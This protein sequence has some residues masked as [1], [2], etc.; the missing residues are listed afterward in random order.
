[1]LPI[2]TSKVYNRLELTTYTRS[3]VSGLSVAVVGCGAL[4]SEVAR[5]LGLLGVGSVM[6]IDPDIV[7]PNNFTHSPYLRTPNSCGRFKAEVLAEN[8]ATHFPD[9]L[10]TALPCEIADAGFCRL[11]RCS[12]LF[13][14]TDNALARVET[15][16]SA[17]RLGLHMIDGGL[18]GHAFW[19]GRVAWL[20]GG[21]GA[22]YLCQL[23]EARRAEL[24]ALGLAASH[25]C[26]VEPG[27]AEIVSSTPTMASI[28]AGM[29]VDLGL[30]FVITGPPS[31]AHAWELSLPLPGTRWNSFAIPRS[32]DC[33]W[34]ERDASLQ[35]V[36]L[37]I[38]IPLNVSLAG[39]ESSGCHSLLVELDWPVCVKARCSTC[40]HVWSPMVR[41]ARLRHRSL[42]PSCGGSSLRALESIAHVGCS[43]PFAVRTPR[44]LGLPE[45]HLF[46][47]RSRDSRATE[48]PCFVTAHGAAG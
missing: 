42:C 4:G 2:D 21:P 14:C 36:Q 29:Q 37:P 31:D 25:N 26:S 3:A 38:D 34:H 28:I 40:Q 30:R 23:G 39:H 5:L 16:Y 41:L 32:I 45:N 44:E 10:W 1:M 15:S 20:P 19:S 47:V 22:C 48:E 27:D 18:K 13:S 17:Y 9:T 7:E 6:L 24:L 8:L 11:H 12:L 43:D 46:S 33:P 35:L